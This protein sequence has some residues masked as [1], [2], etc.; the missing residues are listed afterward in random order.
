MKQVLETYRKEMQE[1]LE[2]I[3]SYWMTYTIDEA[4]GGF[5]GR[6]GH[7]NRIYPEAPKG[8]VLNSRILW[9]FSAAYRLT[10]EQDYLR[11][12]G[13]SFR[14][15]TEFFIDK[16][17][18]GVYWLVDHRGRPADTKKQIYA[19]SFAV[20][21]LSEYYLASRNDVALQQAIR[22]YQAIVRH[23]YD[24]ACGGYLEALSRDW[25]E[26]SDLR[27][28]AKDANEKK[29]MNT[30]LHVLEAFAQL[31]SA[32]PDEGLKQKIVELIRIFLDHIISPQS[33]HLLLFFDE[34]WTARSQVI[35]YGHDIEAAWLI[36]E[37]AGYTGDGQLLAEVKKRSVQLAR[38]A[39][40]GL[41]GDGGLWYEYEGETG[42][43][44]REKHSWP[45]AEAMVGFFNTWQNTGEGAYLEQSL[46]SWAFVK[47]HIRDRQGGE[48]YWGVEED[49][50]P[51]IREDKVGVWKCPYHNSRACM[52]IIKR[53]N[54][55][56]E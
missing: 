24:P 16:D 1:E 50:A 51:M 20:Y 2:S 53:I 7:D 42:H 54:S 36:Q 31:F 40:E 3:L 38:A 32:W 9:A 52:E 44:I 14:Y 39:A 10:G 17:F 34:R 22:L 56:T 4:H 23:S 21:G 6:I 46:K 8:S 18:G 47:E 30:H 25:K 5:V 45:Q 12:A 41:D 48:W 13:R 33:D 43:W 55:L 28:S 26:I 37:A 49:D 29:S 19:L 15:L 35:S 11:M 27:L